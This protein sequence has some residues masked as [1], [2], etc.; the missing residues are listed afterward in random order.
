[1][2]L[3]IDEVRAAVRAGA[4][5]LAL[6]GTLALP[7]IC[8]AVEQPSATTTAKRYKAWFER[9]LAEQYPRLPAADCYKLRCNMMHT[10]FTATVTHSR[11]MFAADPH[12]NTFHNC[13]MDGALV[14]NLPTFC[15]DVIAAVRL[16]QNEKA[17]DPTYQQNMSRL[18]RWHPNGLPPFFIGVPVLG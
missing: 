16:W 2:D 11:V 6:T 4:W 7:D 5:V 15:D 10:G 14:I 9:Y 1:M 18:I 3:L 17:N 12:G 13:E 8:A